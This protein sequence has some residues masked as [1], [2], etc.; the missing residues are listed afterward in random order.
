[1]SAYTQHNGAYPVQPGSSPKTTFVRN[2]I[3]SVILTLIPPFIG[4]VPLAL[5]FAVNHQWKRAECESYEKTRKVLI[6]CLVTAGIIEGIIVVLFLLSF[7][8]I[9]A[10][11]C[12]LASSGF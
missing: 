5:T 1:M 11:C 3:I 6:V 9:L 8:G 4:L 7:F 12:G 10:L 2:L